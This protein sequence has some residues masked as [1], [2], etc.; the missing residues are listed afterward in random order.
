MEEVQT[1]QPQTL[2]QELVESKVKKATKAA[3]NSAST[4]GESKPRSMVQ[5]LVDLEKTTKNQ[6]QIIQF[7]ANQLNNLALQFNGQNQNV[8]SMKFQLQS[9]LE[10]SAGII[11]S[12]RDGLTL[13]E[14]SIQSSIV[15]NKEDNL[16]SQV[17]QLK[18]AGVLSV[19]ESATPKTFVVAKELDDK[20]TL[21]SGRTQ[22]T[23]NQLSE[24]LSS[25]FTGAKTGDKVEIDNGHVIEILELYD[26]VEQK[27]SQTE[28]PEEAVSG[29]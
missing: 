25:K 21:I 23:V 10:V 8:S 5:R 24:D 4:K 16:K 12:L 13:S 6:G 2:S 26:V 7:L 22:F 3:K 17:E 11:R 19:A 20:G 27:T 14:E 15:A 18:A 29:E 1:T 28:S 9:A